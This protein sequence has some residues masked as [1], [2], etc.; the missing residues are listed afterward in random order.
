MI[1]PRPWAPDRA[2]LLLAITFLSSTSR[3][4]TLLE[5]EGA[6]KVWLNRVNDQASHILKSPS[7]N[8]VTRRQAFEVGVCV[9][10]V[11][12]TTT[13]IATQIQKARPV[14]RALYTIIR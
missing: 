5:D 13:C 3:P 8:E 9:T 12:F 4:G 11:V 10:S 7:T 2:A 1:A 6:T 14:G